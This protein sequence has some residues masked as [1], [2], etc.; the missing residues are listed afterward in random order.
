M[1]FTEIRHTGL[2]FSGVSALFEA[3]RP[4]N[5]LAAGLS[6][7][8]GAVVVAPSG[9]GVDTH[10]ALSALVATGVVGSMLAVG[11]ANLRNDAV[12]VW[13]DRVNAPHRPLPRGAAS[14]R[15]AHVAAWLAM[16][17]AAV[18]AVIVGLPVGAIGLLALAVSMA[19]SPYIK[20]TVL[21]GNAVVATISAL[22]V[23]F[24][25]A[26][27]GGGTGHDWRRV[28]FVTLLLALYIGAREVLKCL[29]D[30]E[31]DRRAGAVTVVTAWGATAAHRIVG[32]ASALLVLLIIAA[33]PLFAP[34][35]WRGAGF[36]LLCSVGAVLPLVLARRTF[37][38]TARR[39]HDPARGAALRLT[40][41]G[42]FALLVGALFLVPAAP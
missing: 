4:H 27:A 3:S 38:G 41:V 33:V 30:E 42:G 11:A 5:A 25:A 35:V 10:P 22:T 20:S 31:G 34:S 32:A 15:Q 19:Y 24:G 2:R 21:V 29:A 40:K 6:T 17:G 18:C 8:V 1:S 39:P 37:E 13:A 23:P 7:L 28:W 16:A 12:D 14:V 9:S 36:V 26:L